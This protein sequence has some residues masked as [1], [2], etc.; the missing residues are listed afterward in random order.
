L[1]LSDHANILARFEVDPKHNF[2]FLLKNMP[3]KHQ[4][5]KIDWYEAIYVGNLDGGFATFKQE[6]VLTH[7]NSAAETPFGMVL[8]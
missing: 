3:F 2:S 1:F 8:D 5:I 7:Y 6:G 4:W